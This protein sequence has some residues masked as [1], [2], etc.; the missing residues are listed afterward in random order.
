MKPPA[1][2]PVSL[3]VLLSQNQ[4]NVGAG[5][6]SSNRL[7]S[8][9]YVEYGCCLQYIIL[10]QDHFWAAAFIWE[11]PEKP[12]TFLEHRSELL[13]LILAS[14]LQLQSR[15]TLNRSREK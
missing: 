3:A 7:R 9:N 12:L 15:R 8:V 11:A 10:Q 14:C 6:L 1:C 5:L 13:P 2:F 4:G